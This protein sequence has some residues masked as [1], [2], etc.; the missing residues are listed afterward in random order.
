M[1]AAES[2]GG[3]CVISDEKVMNLSNSLSDR[4]NMD[5]GYIEEARLKR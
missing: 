2:F 5:T 1:A 4:V 3:D